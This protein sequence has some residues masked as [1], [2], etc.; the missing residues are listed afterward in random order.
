MALL[1]RSR[2]RHGDGEVMVVAAG[3]V[4]AEW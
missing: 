4:R 1:P 2:R 3:G